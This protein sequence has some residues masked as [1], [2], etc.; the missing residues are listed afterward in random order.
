MDNKDAD[1]D[2]FYVFTSFIWMIYYYSIVREINNTFT[3]R[4]EILWPVCEMLIV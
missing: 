4:R 3:Y 1:I 2:Y